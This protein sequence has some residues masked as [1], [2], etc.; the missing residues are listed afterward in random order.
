M[1]QQ[2][3]NRVYAKTSQVIERSFGLLFGRFRELK[4]LDMNTIY[5]IPAIVIACCVL[6]IVCLDNDDYLLEEHIR[7]GNNESIHLLIRTSP[8]PGNTETTLLECYLKEEQ[9]T[10]R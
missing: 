2:Y 7:E 8:Q 9:I 6:H 5:L 3:F 4:C 1:Q 10:L